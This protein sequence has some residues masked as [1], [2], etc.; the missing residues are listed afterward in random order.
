MIEKWTDDKLYRYE[1]YRSEFYYSRPLSLIPKSLPRRRFGVCKYR[2]MDQRY[3]TLA[4]IPSPLSS[5]TAS[6]SSNSE[7]QNP[8]YISSLGSQT[9][10]NFTTEHLD[11]TARLLFCRCID[12]TIRRR[13][14]IIRSQR[15]QKQSYYLIPSPLRSSYVY[16]LQ[17]AL[18][19]QWL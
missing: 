19:E 16:W 1:L 3:S 5:T 17:T 9:L 14:E 18:N 15:D 12:E 13:L 2:Y 7:R 6:K 4:G 11:R 10:P 8:T